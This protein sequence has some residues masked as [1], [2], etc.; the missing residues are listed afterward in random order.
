MWFKRLAESMTHLDTDKI[1]ITATS[2]E[3][4]AANTVETDLSTM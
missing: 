3:N 1:T 4:A 2:L